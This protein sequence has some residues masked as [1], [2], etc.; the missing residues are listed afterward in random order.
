[1][2]KK[3]AV[4]KKEEEI[5]QDELGNESPVVEDIENMDD[6]EIT[7]EEAFGEEDDEVLDKEEQEVVSSLLEKEVQKPEE[8]LDIFKDEPVAVLVDKTPEKEVPKKKS[9]VTAMLNGSPVAL[10]FA[11]EQ[12]RTRKDIKIVE[13]SPNVFI[14]I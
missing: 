12:Q 8:N 3:K 10:D 1:M 6:D 5:T 14:T 13:T 2:A 4:E 9:L 11:L 7:V